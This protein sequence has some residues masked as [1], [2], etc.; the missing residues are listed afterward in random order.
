[1]FVL[2][3]CFHTGYAAIENSWRTIDERGSEIATT[4]V[5]DCQL[6]PVG[7]LMAIENS[8]FSIF[9]LRSSIILTFSI[10]AY[11]LWIRC[12]I[13]MLRWIFFAYN[14]IKLFGTAC[15]WKEGILQ[16]RYI[17]G[18]GWNTL[19]YS[20]LPNVNIRKRMFYPLITIINQVFLRKLFCFE[21]LVDI[22]VSKH[23]NIFSLT[24]LIA[25]V[26]VTSS[27]TSRSWHQ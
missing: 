26:V 7:R 4:S 16:W 3:K 5:F 10:A 22:E 25:L 15:A 23:L 8:V 27:L 9:G 13:M 2:K 1:M 18:S 6:S 24:R 20:G 11:P 14:W 21:L 19:S 17:R 12:G